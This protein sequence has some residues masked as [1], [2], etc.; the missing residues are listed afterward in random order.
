MSQHRDH[1]QRDI[2]SVAGTIRAGRRR[3]PASSRRRPRRPRR[4]R[5]S[6]SITPTANFIVFS[7]TRASG[8][9]GGEP[10]GGHHEHG[11]AGGRRG[12]RD[13]VLVG[14]EGEHDERDLQALEQNAFERDRER[15]AVEVVG[16]RPGRRAAAVS[17][18]KAASSS[19]SGLAARAARR[20]AL[21]SHCR[22][23]ISSRPPTTRCRTSIGSAVSAGP[24]RGDDRRP[25]PAARR[26][27][28]A[29]AERQLR[30]VPTASTIVS[31]S[32][33]STAQARKTET[34]SPASAPLTAPLCAVHARSLTAQ[35]PQQRAPGLQDIEVGPTQTRLL[36]RDS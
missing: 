11:Q 19:C 31:A 27:R 12:Q 5:R 22:P 14:A 35:E 17:S 6:V 4:C 20:I 25:A 16:D 15:V 26:R 10:E 23:K 13:V 33:A 21:R 7:G 9:S 3:L 8:A 1:R 28:R 24:D 2:A 18:A 29:S 32:T 30:V 34:A 36:T